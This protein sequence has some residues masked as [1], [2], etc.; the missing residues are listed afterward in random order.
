MTAI[1]N[2][3]FFLLCCFSHLVLITHVEPVLCALLT[4][5]RN[6]SVSAESFLTA[7][8]FSVINSLCRMGFLN[9]QSGVMFVLKSRFPHCMFRSVETIIRGKLPESLTATVLCL[10]IPVFCCP[11]LSHEQNTA[12]MRLL[13]F[14]GMAAEF[15]EISF[16]TMQQELQIGAE[17]VEAFVI[18]GRNTASNKPVIKCDV[19]REREKGIMN[20]VSDGQRILRIGIRKLRLRT[21]TC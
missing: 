6:V 2:W 8:G 9:R 5:C 18:D 20:K 4:Q 13:T 12:K 16:D 7:K 3:L 15:K 21:L 19:S 10:M 11:G 14:M 1:Y 17:D